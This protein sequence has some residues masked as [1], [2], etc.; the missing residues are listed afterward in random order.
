L[1]HER[2]VDLRL[3][4][5]GESAVQDDPAVFH[6][7]SAVAGI[8]DPEELTLGRI[9]F[10]GEAPEFPS[11]VRPLQ[12]EDVSVLEDREPIEE[13]LD[14][15]A[16]Q[17]ELEIL[18]GMTAEVHEPLLDGGRGVLLRHASVSRWGMVKSCVWGFLRRRASP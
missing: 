1:L 3:D 10:Q 8:Q 5:A 17:E 16:G 4:P 15:L 7:G 2:V 11:E 6:D 18:A 12:D 9:D 14:G 13:T